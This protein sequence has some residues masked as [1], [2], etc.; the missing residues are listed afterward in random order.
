MNLDL[1]R[2]EFPGRRIDYYETTD[3]T[4]RVAATLEAGVVVIANQQTAGQGRHGHSWHSEADAGLYVSIVLSPSPLL[5]LALGLAARDAIS[6]AC[7]LECDI[8]WPNDLMLDSKKCGGIL[9]QL[10]DGRAIGGIGI[11]VNHE[12]FPPGFATEA[13]SLRLAAGRAFAREEILAHLLRAV[14]TAT[15]FAPA[16]ILARFTAASTYASGLRV[17]VDQPGGIVRGVTAGLDESGFLRVRQDDGT[18]TLI[19][20]GGVRAARA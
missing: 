19:L 14:D 7:N 20:A 18:V 3:S 2:R 4:M 9:A 13:T 8:R 6:A 17:T 15:A 16:Q 12:Q 11:N 10:V 1:L 5:T